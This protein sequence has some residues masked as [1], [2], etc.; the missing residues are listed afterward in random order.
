MKTNNSDILGTVAQH[1]GRATLEIPG[2]SD[3]NG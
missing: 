1:P 2:A 3:E